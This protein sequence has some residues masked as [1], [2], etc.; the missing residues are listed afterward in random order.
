[1]ELY[2]FYATTLQ[3]S[4]DKH[5]KTASQDPLTSTLVRG[6][7]VDITDLSASSFTVRATL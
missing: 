7:E 4:I 6:F 5:V 1:M 3:S 2:A